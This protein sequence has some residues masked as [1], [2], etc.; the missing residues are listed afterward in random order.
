MVMENENAEK[1]SHRT[2]TFILVF[3]G[4]NLILIFSIKSHLVY[5]LTYCF[6]IIHTISVSRVDSNVG[7]KQ[8]ANSNDRKKWISMNIL[9][10]IKE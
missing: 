5:M 9:F 10:R 2:F 6:Y 7:S 4:V 1:K 3:C 8:R